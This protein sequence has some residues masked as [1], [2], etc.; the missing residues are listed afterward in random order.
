MRLKDLLQNKPVI[1]GILNITPDSFSDGGHHNSVEKAVERAGGFLSQGATILDIGGES[2]R[3][4]ADVVTPEDEIS[5]V[6]PV[7]TAIIK[8][9]PEAVISIDTRNSATMRAALD[10]GASM[11][12]DV[13][14]LQHDPESI[15]LAT[16]AD[17]PVCLMH[18]KGTPEDMQDKPVYEDVIQEITNFFKERV[19]FCISHDVKKENIILD[20]GIGFGKTVHH[21]L[22]ILKHI[23][24]FK[25]LG[26]PLLIGASRKSFIAKIS[27]N[28]PVDKRLGGSIASALYASE[29]GA[30]ILRV[31]DV[32]ET[33]Q[34]LRIYSSIQSSDE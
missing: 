2:T 10:A 30:D 23:D 24:Q 18:M 34:A 31:H 20:P 9:F 3:P 16:E 5:R 25:S 21:N 32:E 17:V 4:Y 28:A 29:K 27:E 12:N 22:L 26:Y 14:A 7:I 15:K 1:M 33:A 8:K 19:E 11:I 6:V 13:S